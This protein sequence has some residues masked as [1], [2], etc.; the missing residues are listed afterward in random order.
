MSDKQDSTVARPGDEK[1]SFVIS[2]N[3][4]MLGIFLS[5]PGLGSLALGLPCGAS[6]KHPITTSL[7]TEPGKQPSHLTPAVPVSRWG[8]KAGFRCCRVCLAFSLQHRKLGKEIAQ[9]L[10]RKRAQVPT[11]QSPVSLKSKRPR[12]DNKEPGSPL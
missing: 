10:S 9:Q 5:P 12:G 4:H 6:A 7:R 11:H 8:S 1:G 3:R 2:D